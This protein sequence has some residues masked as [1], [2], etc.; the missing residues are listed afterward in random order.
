MPSCSTSPTWSSGSSPIC[1]SSATSGSCSPTVRPGTGRRASGTASPASWP[2]SSRSAS[3]PPVDLSFEGG[4]EIA[5]RLDPDVT[6]VIA[7]VDN[8][9]LGIVQRLGERG[10]RVP[11]DVSVIGNN[12]V[13]WARMAN[14][15]L[16]TLHTPFDAMGRAAVS[17]LLDNESGTMGPQI[18]ETFRSELVV[19]RSTAPP[20][21]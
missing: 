1:A 10:I 13:M 18:V 20:R 6:A 21:A 7:F 14:P 15:A 17:L 5:D 11:D 12:D 8:Q 3:P 19:R 2:P 16:T 4:L 9:A